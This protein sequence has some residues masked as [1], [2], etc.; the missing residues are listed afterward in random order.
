LSVGTPVLFSNNTPW[1]KLQDSSAG[2]VF[3]LR[4]KHN[5]IKVLQYLN[6]L[7]DNEL[8]KYKISAL[9]YYRSCY[10][11]QNNLQQYLRMFNC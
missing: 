11:K 7:K 3:S 2:W 10:N 5:F 4:D 8:K 1:L 9:K 6:S